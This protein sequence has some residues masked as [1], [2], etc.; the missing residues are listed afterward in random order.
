[1]PHP[2]TP[3]PLTPH[4]LTPHPLAPPALEL[5][6]SRFKAEAYAVYARLRAEQ[7][8]YR[9]VN[10][11]GTGATCFITRYDDAVTV[12]RDSKLFVKDLRNTL[13]PTARAA[14]PLPPLL[15]RLTSHHMLNA[16]P[17]DHTRLRALVN[18]A[19]TARMVEQL[20]GKVEQIAL[21][22]IHAMLR[23]GEGDLI[24]DF[25]FP[26]PVIVIAEL[27]GVPARDR[28]RFRMW[29]SALSAPTPDVARNEKKLARSR[30]VM[31]DYIGYL[32]GI[33][34]AR[35]ADPRDDLIT[36][37]LA[38]EDAGD[39]LSEDELF[40]MILLL[41][42]VGH[43]TSVNLIGNGMLA[44]LQRRDAWEYLR[45]HPDAIPRAVEEMLRYDCPVE[46]APMRYAAA[47]VEMGGTGI[48]RGDAVSVVLGS[49]NR[50]DAQ[51]PAADRFEI[52]R[53]PNRHLAFG[54][55][56]HYCLGAALARLEGRVAVG[57]LLAHLPTLRLAVEPAALRW[58]THPIMRGLHHLPVAWSPGPPPG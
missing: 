41:I 9:R 4:P 10:R 25:A 57:A 48:R 12:L 55:G 51:F 34:A 13:E 35:R 3:H 14:H 36:S 33:F 29:T 45:D 20:H 54:L 32:R 2:L 43:E 42:V 52:D 23:K 28:H 22:L 56:I 30:Q 27:L 7:P 46:R 21:D 39:A 37:L 18:K 1:M 50:D 31:E 47:D 6:G 11:A 17:P 19:F 26:L 16:D 49:A 40:S 24:E 58:H 5:F 38:A 44:L 8:V 15:L 53:D